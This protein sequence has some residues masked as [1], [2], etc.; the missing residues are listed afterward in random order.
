MPF[1]KIFEKEKIKITKEKGEIYML[2]IN[3]LSHRD[4]VPVLVKPEQ[5][6]STS[7]IYTL[8]EGFEFEN[9]VRISGILDP[10]PISKWENNDNMYYRYHMKSVRL[11]GTYDTMTV[12]I[13]DTL[14]NP[15]VADHDMSVTVLGVIK[16][17]TIYDD[18]GGRH[19]DMF[20]LAKEVI[21]A[22]PTEGEMPHF[23][24]VRLAGLVVNE[25][26]VRKTPNGMEIAEVFLKVKDS[27]NGSTYIP[28]I[29]WGHNAKKLEKVG[30]YATISVLGR[31]QSRE[32]EKKISEKQRVK[33]TTYEVSIER[34]PYIHE[35]VMM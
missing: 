17:R 21:P 35:N 8:P 26:F 1:W 14:F 9:D 5:V 30:K 23:N 29:A 6:E 20:V 18:N 7:P 2:N 13:K 12:V 10:H 15:I 32:Y 25:P 34:V 31:Y 33:K 19:K 27:R 28:C 4:N 22:D 3:T 24:V 16:V 11:S